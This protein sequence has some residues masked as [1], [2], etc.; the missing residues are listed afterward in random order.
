MRTDVA[1]L[2]IC[3]DCLIQT[4]QLIHLLPIVTYTNE[5]NQDTQFLLCCIV[6]FPKAQCPSEPRSCR[7]VRGVSYRLHL[8]WL[9]LAWLV[10]GSQDPRP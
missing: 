2:V 10:D 5:A 4:S 8:N 6:L 9:A 3:V 7:Q 1:S